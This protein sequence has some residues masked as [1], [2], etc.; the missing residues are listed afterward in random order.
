MSLIPRSAQFIHLVAAATRPTKPGDQGLDGARSIR[1]SPS[2]S[3]WRAFVACK[4]T[5]PLP[6]SGITNPR[7]ITES[8][9]VD[10]IVHRAAGMRRPNGEQRGVSR[11]RSIILDPPAMERTGNAGFSNA[12]WVPNADGDFAEAG[13]RKRSSRTRT[14]TRFVGARFIISGSIPTRRRIQPMQRSASLRRARP[15]WLGFRRQRRA[16]RHQHP[17]R[18][19]FHLEPRR[20]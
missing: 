10:P 9:R 7:S 18:L 11:L 12:A 19:R 3:R 8:H 2:W 5:N 15:F 6:E 1:S 17:P 20:P 14:R 16:C 4:V 13:T